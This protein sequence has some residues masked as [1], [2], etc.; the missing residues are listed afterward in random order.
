VLLKPA[1]AAVKQSMQA[2]DSYLQSNQKEQ[3]A[4]V[5][6]AQRDVD[7]AAAALKAVNATF[8]Q[9]QQRVSVG[10]CYKGIW[11]GQCLLAVLQ[12]CHRICSAAWGSTAC[13]TSRTTWEHVS[14]RANWASSL[15]Q[16][17]QI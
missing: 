11:R 8:S 14:P 6:A 5:A 7:A 17:I 4:K 10:M 13:I 3:S 9:L 16:D 2:A 12:V 1:L 15:V